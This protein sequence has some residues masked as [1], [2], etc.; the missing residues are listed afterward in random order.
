MSDFVSLYP[1]YDNWELKCKTD[2]AVVI[3]Y[4][5]QENVARNYLINY[6]THLPVLITSAA[7]KKE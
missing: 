4:A 3:V 7:R 2:A 5:L 6:N 1:T